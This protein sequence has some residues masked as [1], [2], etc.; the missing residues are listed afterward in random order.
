MDATLA[1]TPERLRKGSFDAPLIDQ[2]T[3]RRAYM[4]I[5]A[6]ATLFRADLIEQEHVKASEKFAK[7]YEGALGF[8]VRYGDEVGHPDCEEPRTYHAQ[9][10]AKACD[11]LTASQTGCMIALVTDARSSLEAL[12][13]QYSGYSERR[14]AKAAATMIVR[15]ACEQL[16]LHWGIKARASP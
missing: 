12:G 1:P 15:E 8:D 13:R 9:M 14:Q 6:F 5:N 11:R 2:Q 3:Q 7:H 4:A 10:I 16:A